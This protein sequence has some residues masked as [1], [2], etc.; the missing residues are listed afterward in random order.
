M[1]KFWKKAVLGAALAASTVTAV[2][3]AAAE[4]W[5]GG[6]HRGGGD[7][8]GAAIVGGVIGLALGAAIASGHHDRDYDRGYYN[9]GYV[10]P[11]NPVYEGYYYRDGFY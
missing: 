11:D 5:R 4:P 1:T 7:A 3:P 8:A 10:Y 2:S 9:E 6:Y